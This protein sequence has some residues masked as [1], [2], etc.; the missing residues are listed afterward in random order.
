MTGS[1]LKILIINQICCEVNFDS[2][3]ELEFWT[4]LIWALGL[5]SV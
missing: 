4:W 3:W 2:F 1:Q 5:C